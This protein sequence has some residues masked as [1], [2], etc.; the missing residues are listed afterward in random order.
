MLVLGIVHETLMRWIAPP[1]RVMAQVHAFIPTRIDPESG[2]R[3]AVGTPDSVQV[4]AALEDG[5]R[6]VYQISGVTPYGQGMGIW[7]YGSGGVLHYD[8]IADRIRGANRRSGKSQTTADDLEEISIPPEKAEYQRT[9]PVHA[10]LAGT[11]E[12]SPEAMPLSLS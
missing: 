1:M 8:L 2:V 7:L 12:P 6:V 11:F 9:D 5:A 10:L 3:R 4:L